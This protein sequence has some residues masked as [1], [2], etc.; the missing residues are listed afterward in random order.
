MKKST[1]SCFVLGALVGGT[2]VALTT[3][4]SGK[5]LRH[6][7]ARVSEDSLDKARV[8]EATHL[9]LNE[10]LDEVKF[11]LKRLERKLEAALRRHQS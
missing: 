10:R 4:K 9:Q 2:V 3:P 6:D 11:G 5:E 1:I 8:F 7:I